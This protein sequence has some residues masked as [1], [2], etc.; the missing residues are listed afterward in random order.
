MKLFDIAGELPN[1]DIKGFSSL[2]A[3][4]VEG[5]PCHFDGYPT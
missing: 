3:N 4:K 5:T 2:E 1:D